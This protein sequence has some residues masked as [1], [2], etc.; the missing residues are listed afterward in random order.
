M[1][2]AD[3]ADVPGAAQGSEPPV[4]IVA[5]GEPVEIQVAGDACATS[6]DIR[7][8]NLEGLGTIEQ[9]VQLNLG[10]SPAYAAQNRWRL[11][12]P[13]GDFAL[14]ADLQFGLDVSVHRE[15]QIEGLGF[16]VPEAFLVDGDGNRV[17]VLPGCGPTIHLANGYSATDNCDSPG[18]P[19]GLDVLQVQ[20]WSAVNLEIPG[21]TITALDGACGH[22]S[23]TEGSR[24]FEPANGCWLGNFGVGPEASPESSPPA[25]VRFLARPGEQVVQLNISASRD[26]D[27]FSVPM[28]GLVDGE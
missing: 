20:A 9:D 22:L 13:V 8:V 11:P 2:A 14:V 10:E 21:W 15:W 17:L 24:V 26:G 19:D 6:W 7:V 25:P 23:G 1:R 27:T 28:Y 4:V 5:L 12:V 18:Y 16:I 3:D